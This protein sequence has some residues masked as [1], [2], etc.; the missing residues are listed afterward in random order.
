MQKTNMEYLRCM[1]AFSREATLHFHFFENGEQL[2]RERI[3]FSG[4]K[5]FPLIVGPIWKGFIIQESK[6]EVPKLS[7]F[8]KMVKNSD[9]PIHL[10]HQN[11]QH[12]RSRH[13]H[14]FSHP[15]KI[16]IRA[17]LMG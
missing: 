8:K 5:F 6:Q 16:H 1:G 10:S 11:S 12:G 7:S 9:V 15:A 13:V 3:Y 2:L 17:Q 4:S 14:L